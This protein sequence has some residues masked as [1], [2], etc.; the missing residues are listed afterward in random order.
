MNMSSRAVVLLLCLAAAVPI[1]ACSDADS[2][3]ETLPDR[4]VCASREPLTCNAMAC[5]GGQVCFTPIACGLGN[6]CTADG[7]PA[8]TGD[9]KCHPECTTD[10]NCPSGQTCLQRSAFYQCTDGG[11]TKGI[12]CAA[13]EKC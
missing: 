11:Q 9:N 7:H 13:S 8:A 12:C 2:D 1:A 6:G 5:P 10:A 4:T 3:A